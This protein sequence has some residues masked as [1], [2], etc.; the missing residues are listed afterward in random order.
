MFNK[1]LIESEVCDKGRYHI[2]GGLVG[3]ALTLSKERDLGVALA[4]GVILDGGLERTA[5]WDVVPV[6]GRCA[7]VEIQTAVCST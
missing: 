7:S 3:R 2:F 4:S 5:I 6:F 1:I